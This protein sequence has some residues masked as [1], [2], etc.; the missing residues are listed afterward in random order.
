M[1]DGGRNEYMLWEGKRPLGRPRRRWV[2]NIKLYVLIFLMHTI[3]PASVGPKDYSE[4][5]K[6]EY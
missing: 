3:L 4:S 6:D 1:N 2:D 5:H